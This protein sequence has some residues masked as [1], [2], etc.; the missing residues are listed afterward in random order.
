MPRGRDRDVFAHDVEDHIVDPRGTLPASRI[1][2][3][4]AVASRC[5]IEHDRVLR[6]GLSAIDRTVLH[7]IERCCRTSLVDAHPKTGPLLDGFRFD[8]RRK[9]DT[10]A[11]ILAASNI[12]MYVPKFLGSAFLLLMKP[13]RRAR[14]AAP[15]SIPM[16]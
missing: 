5:D 4:I 3:A 14:R 9:P 6:P 7:V 10:L 8:V 1:P 12:C 13:A 2:N 16:S 11:S 15:A